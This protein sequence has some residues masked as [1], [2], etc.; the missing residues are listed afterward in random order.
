MTRRVIIG[1]ALFFVAVLGFA[2]VVLFVI[3]N[4][5]PDKESDASARSF[6][7]FPGRD[8]VG[9]LPSPSIIRL[10][11]PGETERLSVR[12]YFSDRTVNELD[13]G[14]AATVSFSSSAP[15]VAE[16]DS[17]G[18]VTGLAVGGADV[19]VSYGDL[20][21]TVP[22]FVWGPM[23]TVPPVD[24][25]RLL[26]VSDNGSAI[27]L[28]RVMVELAPGYNADDAG[29]V[30]AEIEGQIAFEYRTFPGYLLVVEARS[31]EELEVV[32]SALEEDPRVE[33]AY[34]DLF[35]APSDGEEE[36][37]PPVETLQ[38]SYA[39][40]I[41][42]RYAGMF[43]AWN[44][45]N[46]QIGLLNPVTIVMIDKGFV[47]Q[48]GI[49]EVDATIMRE[50]DMGRIQVRQGMGI[51]N[52]GN[53]VAAVMVARNNDQSEPGTPDES[54]SG[55]VSSVNGL[56][57]NLIMYLDASY[58]G[59]VAAS[60]EMILFKDQIDVINFSLRAN[61]RGNDTAICEFLLN[62]LKTHLSGMPDVTFVFAASNEAEDASRTFPANLSLELANGITVGGT[63]G[64]VQRWEDS[65][66]GDAITLGAPGS[67]W[68]IDTES[69]SG[70][71][72]KQGT[73][74][75]A[76]MVS[77]TVAL[78]KALR[79]ELTPE[80]IKDILVESAESHTI[81][82][83]NPPQVG[84][85]PDADQ[86]DWPILDAG[87]AVGMLLW[88]SVKARIDEEA[89][90]PTEATPGSNV[91][92]TV[93]VVNTGNRAWEF[94]LKGLLISPSQDFQHLD[95][96]SHLVQQG[97]SEAF[98]L[99][100]PVDQLGQW[101]VAVSVYRNPELTS[102]ADSK[103]LRLEVVP[104]GAP[105]Q[106]QP[107]EPAQS[108]LKEEP[109]TASSEA[110]EIAS[111]ESSPF[112][113]VS[114]GWYQ[115]CGVRGGGSVACW[116]RDTSGQATPPTGS[117]AS[118]SAGTNHTCGVRND[119]AVA[120]WGIDSWGIDSSG[121]ATPPT[122]SFASVSAGWLHTC[123]V[124]SDGSVAC[125]GE[126]DY[127]QATPPTGSFASVS[128][129]G[130]HTCGLRSDGSVACWGSGSSGQATPPTGSFASV[131][132][133]TNH[134]CGLRS[135]GSVACWGSDRSGQATPPTGSFASVSAGRFHTCG[136]R[137]DG[138][139]ACWGE[140]DYGQAT[141]PTGS[142]ASVS[143][144]GGH[145]C[146]LR[147][148]GSVACWGEDDY[149]QAT[150]PGGSFV[151]V[152]AG[153]YQTCGVRGGGSVACW[154]SG[155]SGQATPPTGSFASVSAGTNH[156]CGVRSDGSVACWGNNEDGQA[157]PPSGSFASVSA[158][159]NHTCGLRN[160]GSVACWG[161]DRYGQATPPSG[162][163]AS[164]S[165]GS[166]HT[167]GLRNDGSVACWGDDEDG[168]ATPPG[169]SFVSV[170]AG[171]GHTCG[172]RSDGSVACW[173]SGSFGKANPPTGSF[174]SVSAGGIHT[175]GLRNDGS[176][177]CWGSGNF[178]HAW[179]LQGSFVSVSAGR[180]HTCGMRS[181]GSV[182]CWGR[183]ARGLTASDFLR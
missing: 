26:E 179:L 47:S 153:W 175:C 158:G 32:L 56:E 115:T 39:R 77:G 60:E 45:M 42:Y 67:I 129:G 81:C 20:T 111:D 162:S 64:Q 86:E 151:S 93:Q 9:I 35:F 11:A 160:D 8:L 68:T 121:Q 63:V 137:S 14:S 178:R 41:S 147:N 83:S 176:V 114:A 170:S 25:Q 182:A 142:F 155:S 55:V 17:R 65:N 97:Q 22:V 5:A 118:V 61:C 49:A 113:S 62:R 44:I 87:E 143:A 107:P 132:A 23:R 103:F 163:F 171:G 38:L 13:D 138:S 119:G 3:V 122:G 134:T 100:F 59:I 31:L 126:D 74:F 82:T 125:W 106:L 102:E 123:G 29:E 51:G 101:T 110:A 124:R 173:G 57:Y 120:C 159:G 145:T 98:K 2:A 48:T 70:Y 181:G 78:L 166:N 139:V 84:P 19:V 46:D 1:I 167:C 130:G 135:D 116:G 172:V 156:T 150:P 37:P 148:D 6:D 165:A 128:A 4:Y 99:S 91:E 53:G 40:Q 15:S 168:Q 7:R 58:A 94:H 89:S 69:A 79:P 72:E 169:G 10:D 76:P 66:F 149:G 144:G 180:F 112:V 108:A 161:R 92:L 104:G 146:G 133:G 34:P 28:N 90:Q 85:C 96:V 105:L 131:S 109:D 33:A 140:D 54:F 157:T 27:V 50:F 12:G 183:Q 75:S 152:S 117:F 136:V 43:E 73:S 141:P 24:P 71:G 177:A 95:T 16:V 154:G 30:A 36:A 127:G 174:V 164:V 80:Q 21:A 88:P 52:H 18:V